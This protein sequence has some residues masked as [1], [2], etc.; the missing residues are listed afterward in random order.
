MNEELKKWVKLD[1][2]TIEEK[3]LTDLQ[4]QQIR[5][6][7]QTNK[8]P[9]RYFKNLV[10]AAV[11]GIC[12]L[13]GSYFALPTIASQ[14][15]FIENILTRIAPDF[16]PENYVDLATVINQVESS[17]GIDLMIENAVYD[18]NTL[19]VTYAIRTDLD[20][21]E[22]PSTRA[23]LDIKGVTAASGVS[24]LEK[25]EDGVYIGM[26]KITPFSR[27]DIGES[28]QVKWQP[29]TITNTETNEEF[30]GDWSF[31]FTMEALPIITQLTTAKSETEKVVLSVPQ[32]DYT[33]LTAVIHYEFDVDSA[34]IKQYPL[35][36]VDIVKVTDNLGNEHEIH[37]NGGAIS[38][39]GHGFDWSLSIYTLTDDVTS[40]TVTPEIS[41]VKESG[42]VTTNMREMMEP[43]TIELNK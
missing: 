27:K 18:G 5:K 13:T 11:I 8:A 15:P 24:S 7:I 28:I 20:L 29:G 9:K 34:V 14:V 12:T 37:G 3:P 41:Y 30:K 10:A 23:M 26:M 35:L 33:D 39:A 1:V 21:G 22:Q 43:V 38:D 42:E 40:V 31:V 2:E 19:M 6:V 4:K 32:I 25:V 16:I 17:N 36:T